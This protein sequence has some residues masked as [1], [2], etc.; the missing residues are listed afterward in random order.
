M[1]SGFQLG[2]SQLLS[3]HLVG[4]TKF[5]HGVNP[6]L[7][8]GLKTLL[9]GVQQLE[10][11]AHDTVAY[12]GIKLNNFTADFIDTASSAFKKTAEL[13][14]KGLSVY[15]DKGHLT[16]LTL[17]L[18]SL[19]ELNMNVSKKVF[20]KL[21]SR[22]HMDG[23][24]ANN[25]KQLANPLIDYRKLIFIIAHGWKNTGASDACQMVKN[26]GN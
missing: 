10:T 5:A 8:Q 2:L 17:E 11:K 16:K 26:G 24:P 15:D 6:L 9:T 18:P 23:V 4:V 22:N 20:F 7:G 1:I 21:Y 14:H 13:I 25:P 3:R 19:L 12:A